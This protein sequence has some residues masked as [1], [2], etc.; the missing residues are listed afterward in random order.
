VIDHLNLTTQT[1][2]YGWLIENSHFLYWCYFPLLALL[3]G[4]ANISIFCQ[5]KAVL[6]H[7]TVIFHPKYNGKAILLLPLGVL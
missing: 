2:H 4:T 5:P 6:H 7:S 1:N 3:Q